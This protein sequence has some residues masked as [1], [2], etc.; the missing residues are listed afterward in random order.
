MFY[1]AQDVIAALSTPV[2]QGGVAVIRVS[3]RGCVELC[4]TLFAPRAKKTILDFPPRHAIYGE[5]Y[6]EV[7]PIDSALLTYFR[8]PSSYTGEDMVELSCHGGVLV[9][10]MVLRRVLI[11]GA[12]M[13]LPGEFTRRALIN[14][15]MTLTEAE[16]VGELLEAR[17]ERGARLAGERIKGA[18]SK[19]LLPIAES[20]TNLISS[21]YAFI[22]YPQEDL[23]DMDDGELVER[24]DGLLR[25]C[26]ALLGTYKIGKAVTYGVGTVI[27]GKPNA[28]KSSLFNALAGE[29]KAIVTDIPGTTRDAIERG[30]TVNGIILN[31]CDT[32]G[33]RGGENGDPVEKL[34]I[35]IAYGKLRE[36][37]T[38]LILA[39]FD[40]SG[41]ADEDDRR[42]ISFLRE[43]KG[44]KIILPLFS[45]SD[46]PPLFDKRIVEE[47]LGEGIEY[48]ALTGDGL[49][50][51]RDTVERLFTGGALSG[52]DGGLLTTARQYA[53]LRAAYD[54][55]RNAK[56]QVLHAYKDMAG[57]ILEEALR[58][59][60]EI[61]SRAVSEKIVDNI[62]AKFC[63]GK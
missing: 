56:E 57:M 31:L 25:D 3:G 47:A 49:P 45:K 33:I 4:G 60:C 10:S 11:A 15:K 51:V 48:S 2:G 39:L 26:E 27:T 21:L 41:E 6:D 52:S 23:E 53:G 12:R 9:S 35:E 58:A 1:A 17:S 5:V 16:A 63:V 34:G 61:D 30:V 46:R 13:A 19:K 29:Q 44:D 32:A 55:I 50:A 40:L 20:L 8:G 54:S 36:E 18:L 38:E 28:G 37:S 59:V 14:D 62:F 42:L 24:L 43:Q 22:D 7:S